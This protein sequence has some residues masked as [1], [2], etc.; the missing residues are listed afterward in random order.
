MLSPAHPTAS[1]LFTSSIFT[2]QFLGPTLPGT[3][4]SPA[5]ASFCPLLL[6]GSTVPCWGSSQRQHWLS[7][8]PAVQVI[9]ATLLTECC[10]HKQDR[11]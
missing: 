9:T 6:C 10:L 8:A 1:A 4:V 11:F 2:A 5:H 3:L 7:S